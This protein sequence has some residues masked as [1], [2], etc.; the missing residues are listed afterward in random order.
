M[1]QAAERD[2]AVETPGRRAT[3]YLRV[4]SA[5]ITDVVRKHF[6]AFEFGG[7]ETRCARYYQD[8]IETLEDLR[9]EV[10]EFSSRTTIR[11]PSSYLTQ[12]AVG[13]A[14]FGRRGLVRRLLGQSWREGSSL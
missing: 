10:Q 1:S 6:E 7:L 8:W 14:A 11:W 13:R 2:G 9:A 4:M 3:G 5:E 12:D